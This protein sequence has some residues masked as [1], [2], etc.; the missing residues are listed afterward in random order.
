MSDMSDVNDVSDM[1]DVVFIG[2]RSPRLVVMG[3][4]GAGKGTQAERIAARFGVAWLSTGE[5]LRTSIEAATP[6]GL[7]AAP[8]V[9]RGDLVPDD[10]VLDL[11]VEWTQ[12]PDVERSGFVLDGVPRTVAQAVALCGA[13][14][15]PFD[16]VI[17]IDVPRRVAVDRLVR[18][19]RGDDLPSAIDRRL[20]S[21]ER[22]AS[23]L[24]A[25]CLGAGSLVRVDGTGAPEV[26]W[27]G[28]ERA[29]EPRLTTSLLRAG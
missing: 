3:R 20:A 8:F 2:A 26:V 23:A 18:R 5:V 16:A 29:L 21:H 9:A 12:R 24:R 1:G 25:W 27:R 11:V 7:L 28:V 15:G 17:E 6:M 14:V 13:G 19:G 10:V 4:Q 22:E